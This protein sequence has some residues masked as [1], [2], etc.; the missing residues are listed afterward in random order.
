MPRSATQV[1][2]LNK[3]IGLAQIL[4]AEIEGQHTAGDQ[5]VRLKATGKRRRRSGKELVNFRK[6]L[7]AERKKGVSV[8]EL[9]QRHGV[10][11]AYIH[12][13]G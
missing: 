11:T 9:A 5:E 13:M 7:K 12:Q 8:A 10:S 1:V 6:L 2:K 4:L 3:I